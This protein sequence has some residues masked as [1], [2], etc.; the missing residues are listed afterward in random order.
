[1][2]VSSS[3]LKKKSHGMFSFIDIF[4]IFPEGSFSPYIIGRVSELLQLLLYMI[5]FGTIHIYLF[6][7]NF[8]LGIQFKSLKKLTIICFLLLYIAPLYIF[9]FSAES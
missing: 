6:P 7:L 1:M 5:F 3:H 4:G 8:N 9:N 2:L